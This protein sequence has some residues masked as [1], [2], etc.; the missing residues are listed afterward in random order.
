MGDQL[1]TALRKFHSNRVL[2]QD[3]FTEGQIYYYYDNVDFDPPAGDRSD[4]FVVK[5]PSGSC[6][7]TTFNEDDCDVQEKFRVDATPDFLLDGDGNMTTGE[8]RAAETA[9]MYADVMLREIERYL[10]D[11]A[12]NALAD[13]R[14][15]AAVGSQLHMW[16]VGR[17]EATTAAALTTATNRAGTIRNSYL[18]VGRQRTQ[19]GPGQ[20][21]ASFPAGTY[22]NMQNALTN[23]LIVDRVRIH[24]DAASPLTLDVKIAER[25]ALNAFSVVRAQTLTH[26]PA[27]PGEGYKNIRLTPYEVPATGTFYVGFHIGTTQTLDTRNVAQAR[28]FAAEPVN[29]ALGATGVTITEETGDVPLIG[30]RYD[31]DYPKAQALVMAT[32]FP[33]WDILSG[34]RAPA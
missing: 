19:S 24:N 10:D 27:G 32:P 31:F 5:Q 13:A 8:E 33:K 23:G 1:G 34:G 12:T 20:T 18:T 21:T 2:A 29:P 14:I 22:I 17:D 4:K 15:E 16:G 11:A 25:T 7:R 3:K 26:T 28:A 30:V 6:Y 9:W